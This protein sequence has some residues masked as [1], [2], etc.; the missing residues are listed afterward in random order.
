MAIASLVK[1]VQAGIAATHEHPQATKAAASALGGTCGGVNRQS[2]RR[3]GGGELELRLPPRGTF[4]E[5][6]RAGGAGI[7]GCFRGAAWGTKRGEGRRTRWEG[8]RES[9]GEEGIQ[10]ELS[11]VKAW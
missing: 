9:V 6:V 8:G 5:K 11:I 4:G 1:G 7:P 2:E 10:A 3:V